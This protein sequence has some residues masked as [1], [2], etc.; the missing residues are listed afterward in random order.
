MNLSTLAIAKDLEATGFTKAQAES[1]AEK[2]AEM[3]EQ[4]RNELVTKD[5]LKVQ[6]AEFSEQQ[7]EEMVTKDYLKVQL[8][9]FSEQL[10][11]ELVTKDQLKAKIAE[12]SVEIRESHINTIKWLI[13]LLSG[14]LALILSFIYFLVKPG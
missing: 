4:Q 3:S 14:F 10:R 1:V 9:E 5:Y 6:F 12:V 8:T 2:F 13:G 11:N 7:R